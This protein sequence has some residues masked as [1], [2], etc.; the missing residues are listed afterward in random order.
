MELFRN[1]FVLKLFLSFP[2]SAGGEQ[3]LTEPRTTADI[4][5]EA[6]ADAARRQELYVDSPFR[7]VVVGTMLPFSLAQMPE[8]WQHPLAWPA[9]IVWTTVVA[10]CFLL[11]LQGPLRLTPYVA[12]VSMIADTLLVLVFVALSGGYR[13]PLLLALPLLML[14]QP[15]V[16]RGSTYLPIY[17]VLTVAGFALVV[18]LADGM[19]G[20]THPQALIKLVLLLAFAAYSMRTVR[21]LAQLNTELSRVNFQLENLAV[22]DELTGLYN[23]RYLVRYLATVED[24]EQSRPVSILLLDLDNFKD[25]NDRFGHHTGDQILR[26]AAKVLRQ[27]VRQHDVVIRYGGDEFAVV[28]P[29]ADLDEAREVARRI[30]QAVGRHRFSEG[31]ALTISIGASAYPEPSASAETL[32]RDADRALYQAKAGGRNEVATYSYGPGTGT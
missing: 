21:G 4:I 7:L 24:R 12:T 25:C 1:C 9:L 8:L 29:D 10:A 18:Y 26:E 11:C 5:A 23:R 15:P 13:S 14:R 27:T 16:S 28:L 30:W 3:T 22:T 32:L 20:L 17:E 19:P 31:F 6:A 2:G